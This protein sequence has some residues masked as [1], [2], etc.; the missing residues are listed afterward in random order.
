VNSIALS[1]EDSVWLARY[2]KFVVALTFVLIFIGG[3]TT[4]AGA[5]MAFPDWPM[6]H[7]SF[8]PDGW[9]NDGMQRLEHGHRYVAESVGLAIG[10]LCAWVWRSG[11][12]VP[13]AFLGAGLV[14]VAAAFAGLAKPSVVHA[15]LWSSVVFFLGLLAWFSRRD[16]RPRPAAVRWLAIAAFLGVCVQAVLGGMR[17]I[18]DPAGALAG[19][20]ATANTLRVIHGCFAQFELCLLVAIAA[21]LSPAWPRLRGSEEWRGVAWLGWITAAFVFLQLAVGATMRH[22]GAGLA[23]PTYPTMPD[24]GWLPNVR[25]A[26][27]HL[28]FTHT[29]LGA[30]V[31]TGF[32]ILTAWRAFSRAG[33]DVRIVRPA[34]LLLALVAV[35]FTLGILVI[36]KMRPPILTTLHVVNGAALLAT[37]VLLAVRASRG[38]VPIAAGRKVAPQLVEVHV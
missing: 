29:R 14:A 7:G 30:V 26:L 6:S 23:I 34:A 31:V 1:E 32:V 16:L 36:W 35:Q 27:I 15:G 20:A 25:S 13:L 9:W 24:G 37:V 4:T 3:H 8:N 5:G 19:E 12:A 28:N 38:V 2:A 18:H 17:V 21:L 10:V 33:G 11:R 22:L